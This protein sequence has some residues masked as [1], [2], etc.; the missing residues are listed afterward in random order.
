MDMTSEIKR[1]ATQYLLGT[2]TAE[3]Q[4]AMEEKYFS[5]PGVFQQVVAAEK[6]LL[7]DYAYGRLSSDDRAQFERHY[8]THPK[9]RARAMTAIALAENLRGLNQMQAAPE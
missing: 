6:K 1:A 8:L 5:D 2:A 4:T 7:D 9:R 3:E